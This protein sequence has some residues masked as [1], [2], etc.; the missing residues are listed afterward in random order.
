MNNKAKINIDINLHD[1]LISIVVNTQEI[2]VCIL[3]LNSLFT[4]Y[5]VIQTHEKVLNKSNGIFFMVS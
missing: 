3:I 2:G 5:S 1:L 4:I